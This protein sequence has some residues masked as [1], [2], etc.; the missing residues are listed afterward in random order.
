M[1]VIMN[2]DPNILLGGKEKTLMIKS[3]WK[4]I[5]QV[6]RLRVKISK[7]IYL[8]LSLV[9]KF[10]ILTFCEAR[11]NALQHFDWL[12]YGNA[13]DG[14]KKNRFDHRVTILQRSLKKATRF[15]PVSY[16]GSAVYLTRLTSITHYQTSYLDFNA[17][18][19]I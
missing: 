19:L 3:L 17:T 15:L 12:S 11:E 4:R 1:I 10:P 13:E 18:G 2:K 14:E 5:T 9:L 16:H 8:F 7:I 6:Y